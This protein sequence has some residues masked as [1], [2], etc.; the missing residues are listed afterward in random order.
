MLNKALNLFFAMFAVV[1]T[2]E[3]SVCR[4]V[5][6]SVYF[7]NSTISF[8]VAND[9]AGLLGREMLTQIL[10]GKCDTASNSHLGD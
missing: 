7:L 5:D 4:P 10:N 9:W 2:H 8:C 3:T 1:I 6:T